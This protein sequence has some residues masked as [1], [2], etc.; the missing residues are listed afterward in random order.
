MKDNKWSD[1]N[2][3]PITLALLFM[4]GVCGAGVI[5]VILDAIFNLG[6]A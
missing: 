2:L 6:L 4:M 3:A 1:P 5:L